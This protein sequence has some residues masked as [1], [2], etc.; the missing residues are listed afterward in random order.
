MADFCLQCSEALGAPPSW[1]DLQSE[2]LTTTLQLCEGC[3]WIIVDATGRCLGNCLVPE[4]SE[5]MSVVVSDMFDKAKT[6]P[7]PRCGGRGATV[8]YLMHVKG[9]KPRIDCPDC[10]GDTHKEKP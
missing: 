8:P 9:R 4:H 2:G 1:S 7:C 5:Q 10:T 6:S 3:G